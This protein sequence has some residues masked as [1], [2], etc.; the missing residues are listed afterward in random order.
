MKTPDQHLRLIA[1]P[2]ALALVLVGCDKGSGTD[3]ATAKPESS[4]TTSAAATGEKEKAPAVSDNTFTAAVAGEP[5]KPTTDASASQSTAKNAAPTKANQPANASLTT[6]KDV[7]NIQGPTRPGAA[8]QNVDLTLSPEKLDLGQMQPGVPKTGTVKITNNG[9]NSVQIKKAVASC[10]C[11]TP[12]WPREPI[13]PGESA[14]IEITLK[15]SLKQGQKLNKRVTLQMMAGPPQVITVAGEVGLFVKMAPDFLDAAKQD[16][17]GQ[18]ALVLSSADEVPF[19]VIKVDPPV[20]LSGVGGDK[21]LNHEMEIDWEA[22]EESG[23]RP[24]IKLTTDHPNAPELSVTVRRAIVSDKNRPLPPPRTVRNIPLNKVVSSAQAQDAKGVAAAIAAGEDVNGTSQGNMTALHWAAKEGNSE[25]VDMLIAAKADV[26]R[27]NKVGKTPVAMAAEGG[28]L[29]ALET[30]ISNGG[31]IDTIDE[32]GGTPLLWAAALSKNP[33]TVSYLLE[34][35]ADVNVVDSNG[36][37]PLIWAAG[38]GQPGS[39]KVLIDKGADVNVVEIHQQENAVMRAARIGNPE[40]LKVL[41]A[42][43][44][45]L[46]AR[47]LLGQTA[48]LIAASSATPEKIKLLVDAGADLQTRDTRQ[49]SVLDHAQARTDQNRAEVIAYFQEKMGQGG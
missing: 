24:L 19:S 4:A 32:I 6:A 9:T 25:I 8:A 23:R 37:T 16:N 21:A 17:D 33:A 40:S 2:A 5:S 38:I 29:E 12:N 47:N 20:F 41:I 44:P 48:L 39:V 42:A 1:L 43:K 49:W 3:K 46:E 14:E 10:G 13:G 30:L 18:K 7:R 35:G 34:K 36:M 45:D 28:N 26:N 22:W 15:P 11:T 27:P 31:E